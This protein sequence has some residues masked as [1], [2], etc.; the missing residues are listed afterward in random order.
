MSSTDHEVIK[1][2][3]IFLNG[4]FSLR[5]CIRFYVHILSV[6][7]FQDLYACS[8]ICQVVY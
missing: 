6:Y 8:H 2:A 1:M 3:G 7:M 5:E 4:K